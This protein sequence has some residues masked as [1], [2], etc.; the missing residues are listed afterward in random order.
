M[1]EQDFLFAGGA[2][3]ADRDDKASNASGGGNKRIK[4]YPFDSTASQIFNPYGKAGLNTVNLQQLWGVIKA[5]TR[6]AKFTS[7]LAA[8][9][10]DGGD[11]RIGIGISR[12][13][14]AII[15]A[16]QHLDDPI[17]AKIL[18]NDLL[19][20]AQVEGHALLPHLRLL[21]AGKEMGDDGT[22]NVSAL[23]KQRTA[24]GSA[25]KAARQR[26]DVEQAAKS[27]HAWLNKPESALRA[28]LHLLAGDGC[29]F[30]AAVA[31]KSARAWAAKKPAVEQDCVNAALARFR[32]TPA[33]AA[34]EQQSDTAGLF[35]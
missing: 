10:A 23:K 13:A 9:E 7:E 26:E 19:K 3:A 16:I 33:R 4:L 14:E 15:V 12:I 34:S 27:L 20:K 1:A 24:S 28:M 29:F 31:E 32:P 6:K 21:D 18:N 8:T 5:G 22:L 2:D 25:A 30:A 35:D 17:M 11:F